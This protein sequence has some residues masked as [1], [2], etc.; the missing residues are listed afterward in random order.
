MHNVYITV[1]NGRQKDS[2]V[3]NLIKGRPRVRRM[4]HKDLSRRN[5]D[6]SLSHNHI[7]NWMTFMF[8]TWKMTCVRDSWDVLYLVC[9]SVC[10][11]W[12]LLTKNVDEVSA[13]WKYRIHLSTDCAHSYV[14]LSNLNIS[15]VEQE[16]GNTEWKVTS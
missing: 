16:N 6:I 10:S 1:D 12:H 15:D 2:T 11:L 8:A 14:L 4:H 3:V 13:N 5:E 9:V 7:G